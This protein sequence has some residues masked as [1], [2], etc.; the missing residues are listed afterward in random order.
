MGGVCVDSNS[1]NNSISTYDSMLHLFTHSL[2][3]YTS[4]QWQT[5]NSALLS[6]PA[7]QLHS[8]P[9]APSMEFDGN[10]GHAT[11]TESANAVPC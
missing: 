2:R 3:F 6:N 9:D 11:H 5:Q 1:N 10:E 4:L 7:L 8:H